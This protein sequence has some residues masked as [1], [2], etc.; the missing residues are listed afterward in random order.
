[1]EENFEFKKPIV[2]FDLETTGLNKS[3]DYIIQFGAI[4]VDPNTKKI[5]DK[6][7]L[8]IQ[9][10]GNYEISIAAYF[11]HGI[12]PDFLKDKPYFRDVANQIIDFFGDCDVL[13]Y[14][15]KRFDIPFLLI[16]M[17][18]NGFTMDF[19]HRNCWDAFA[20]EQRRNGNKLTQTFERYIGKTMDEAGLT[21][22]DALSDVKA[23]WGVFISQWRNQKF[24]PE[25]MCGSDGIIDML[26]FRDKIVPCFTIGKY[27]QLSIEFVY[28]ID[29]DYIAWCLGDKS[30]FTESTKNYI[31]HIIA[32]LI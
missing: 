16:E 24:D 2:V 21:A 29:K 13:T 17:E 18:R 9:P 7:N 15:G 5:I 14:N 28:S 19:E 30:N 11:K 8:F 12:K 27:R 32:K 3:K 1:M 10:S 22:H 6:L 20:E 4:K 25:E 23:T 31:R 26:E